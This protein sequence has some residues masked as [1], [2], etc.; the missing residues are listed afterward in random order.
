M[1][2]ITTIF[3]FILALVL[4]ELEIQIEGKNG[5]AKDLPTWKP[6]HDKWY[7]GMFSKMMNQK[8]ITGYHLSM[9]SFVFLIFH[10]HFFFGVDWT[11]LGELV[12]LSYY[13]IF[14]ALWDFLWFVLNPHYALKK[15]DGKHIWWHKKWVGYLPVEYYVGVAISGILYG[16]ASYIYGVPFIVWVVNLA[17]LIGLTLITILIYLLFTGSK[18]RDL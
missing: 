2:I 1:M 12:A 15:F 13:F 17:L 6:D 10:A 7:V 4:A 16:I 3:V 5:W 9:F 14:V 8:E 18:A 11:W